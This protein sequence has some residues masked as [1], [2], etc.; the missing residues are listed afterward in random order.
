VGN[1]FVR[2]SL[3]WADLL[4]PQSTDQDLIELLEVQLQTTRLLV[5]QFKDSQPSIVW[6]NHPAQVGKLNLR[7]NQI[8][9][10]LKSLAEI[11]KQDQT[12]VAD[13]NQIV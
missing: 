11:L 13:A 4:E 12:P 3:T 7:L 6:R 5:D 10:I 9:E 1:L 8:E 2:K